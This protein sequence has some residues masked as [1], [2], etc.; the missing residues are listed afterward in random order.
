M[1][2]VLPRIAAC[3]LCT[4][5]FCLLSFKMLGA[6][7]QSGYKNGTFLRWLGRKENMQFN[8]LSVLAL[9]LVLASAITALCFSYL[10]VTGALYVS[11]IPFLTLLVFAY[12][13]DG[14]FAL[15]VETKRTGRLCRLFA[16]Y[17]LL[18]AC[19]SYALI[20]FLRFL[21]VW[22]GSEVY[23]LIAY[24]PFGVMPMLLPF[25]LCAA[26]AVEGVF[27]RARNAKFV[28]RAGQVLDETQIIRVGV[29]G[30]Y[31][32]TTVKNIL[33]TVLSEKY[34]VVETPESY[35]TPIGVAKTVFSEAFN[36]KQVF[37]AELGARKAGDIYQLCELVKPD[38]AVFT[39][40]CEQHLH[41]FGNIE[42]VFA[43][44]SEVIASGAFVICNEQLKTR[45]KNAFSEEHI[46][47]T[48]LFA[49]R[50]QVEE[51]QLLPTET[52]FTLRLGEE[53]I[54]VCTK[55]LG[56]AAAENIALAATLAYEALGLSAEEIARGIA[57]VQPVP[58]RLQLLEN[59][60]VYILDDGYNCNPRGAKEA[61]A[62]L[63]RFTGR[64][65]I[66]TP[67]IVECGVLEERLNGELG[68]E[69]AEADLTK[70][71]LVGD[72]LV[73][74]VKTG[75]INAG[76]DGERLTVVKTLAQAQEVLAEWLAAGDCV[77]F[78][79]DLPDVY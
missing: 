6:M 36:G 79:N 65:C 69:I 24:V 17:F 45:V 74:A 5:L 22:N 25:L 53:K 59:G 28:K 55:L 75:Y 12:A 62:A 27:E 11:A 35:N 29:V 56:N 40:V 9:C 72:T 14:K 43:E 39:G 67:G 3:L 70:V 30:S 60:G 71:I 49:G 38:F 34:T 7:Q 2:E 73:G 15:K 54:E 26:N 4:T 20:A 64:K 31:G 51:L 77:L 76:G 66:V 10:G 50:S 23:G 47:E 41:T 8:R 19:V 33:K 42:N 37:I 16:A 63:A 57:K 61:V 1:G 68:K 21:A 18:V 46:N 78:L 44:K 32:K 52:K 48:V 13:A 58:H